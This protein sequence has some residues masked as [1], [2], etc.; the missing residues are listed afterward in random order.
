MIERARLERHVRTLAGEIGERNVFRPHALNAA[1][2]YI[3]EQWR[4]HGFDPQ[5]QSYVARGVESSNLEVVLEGAAEGSP[6]IVV[7]AHYDSVLGSPG[8][9]DNASAVAALLELGRVLAPAPRRCTL[10]L[11]AFVNEEPP[12]FY[13][14]Q[15]GSQV[16]ARAARR[17]GED[18]RV[19]LSLEMLGYYR[20]EPGTQRYPPLMRWFYPNRGNFIGF[21][22]NLRSHRALAR[23]YEA[24]RNHC[25]FPAE[26]AAVPSWVPGVGWSDQL[27]FW[28][29]GY[30]ALMVT[31]TAFYR[32]PYY[33]TAE[34]TPDKVDYARLTQVT[35][36][37]AGALSELVN[38]AAL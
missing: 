20:D 33:H 35:S 15:M 29:Q 37:L 7:G 23:V 22:S 1:R 24:F 36:G 9:D 31:D 5:F 6:S 25:D 10:R 3:A 26:R 18:I 14:G 12:F 34:D 27:S 11:V 16:Y 21:V 13:W 19:M 28:R 2:D 32:Y 30:P 17:R 8:A 4:A 38:T